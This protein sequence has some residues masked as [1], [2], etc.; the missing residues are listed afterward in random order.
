[1]DGRPLPRK[2]S[3]LVVDDKHANFV[4]LEAVLG[5]DYSVTFAASGEQ[6][7]ALLQGGPPV[8]VILMDVQMPGMDGFEAAQKIKAMRACADIPIIF[9]T[10]IYTEDPHVRRGYEV[11]GIDYFSKPFDPDILRMKVAIY[12]SFRLKQDLLRERERHIREAE[13]LLRVG[14]KLA[15]VLEGL[16]VGVLIAD[17][18]GRVCQTTEEVSRILKSAEPAAAGSYGE[19]VGWWNA[20][21]E[22]M[23]E[24]PLARAIHFGESSHSDRLQ[25]RCL[26]GTEKTIL[27]SAFPLR[28]LDGQLIGAVVLIQDFTQ[29]ARIHH[30]LEERVARLVAV[31]IELEQ[32]ALAGASEPELGP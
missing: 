5:E 3:V 1:M 29:T 8:D 14:R 13:E 4:A 20:S 18:E 31:G 21:G 12:A 11:G 19:I 10:A 7:I 16:P 28:G 2:P 6:A 9:I 15:G 32:A 30:D 24:P 27:V 23:K 25:V 26:D 17:V 22:M